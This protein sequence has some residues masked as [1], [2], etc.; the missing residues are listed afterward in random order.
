MLECVINISEGSDIAVL[1]ALEQSCSTCLLDTHVDRHHNRSVFTL[2]GEPEATLE[3]AKAITQT[4]LA[5]LDITFHDGA[6]PRIGVVDVVPFVPYTIGEKSTSWDEAEATR[7]E[8]ARW[9]GNRG[10][11]AF[12]YGKE[13]SLPAIRKG[14]FISFNPE[15]GPNAPHET[16]GSCAV[17][18]RNTLIAYNVW[19]DHDDVLLARKI[20]RTLRSQEVRT[21]G[22]LIGDRAQVSCNLIAPE[23]VGPETIFDRVA[24]LA[25]R[26]VTAEL[27]GLLPRKVLMQQR[28]SRWRLL[29]LA[30]DKTI[31]ER[32]ARL[33]Q[34]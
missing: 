7:D 13:R 33:K 11:P 28:Q 12:L 14:A 8:F 5:H 34:R 23:Q 16:A 2:L 15:F 18:V 20:A 29:D 6:H 3:S 26:T 4:A 31:E 30:E 25:N 17:G 32:Y 1:R 24:S 9:I 10:V 19:F 27:V 22:L 21:L